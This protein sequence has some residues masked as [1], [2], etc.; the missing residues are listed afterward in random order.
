VESTTWLY[1]LIGVSV[2][3]ALILLFIIVF[4]KRIVLAIALIKEGSK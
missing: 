3:F 4:R 2:I 1:I